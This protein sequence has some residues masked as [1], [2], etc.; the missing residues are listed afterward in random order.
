M[1]F[2]TFVC[3]IFN[4]IY[5]ITIAQHH[6][7]MVRMREKEKIDYIKSKATKDNAIKLKNY[8]VK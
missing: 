7:W 2:F 3:I 8:A 6:L 5:V 1:I 4:L